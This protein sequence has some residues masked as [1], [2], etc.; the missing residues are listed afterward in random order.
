MSGPAVHNRL[1]NSLEVGGDM[2]HYC[3]LPVHS[4][5]HHVVCKDLTEV[6]NDRSSHL[7]DMPQP[8]CQVV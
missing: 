4:A 7:G 2:A 1:R 6:S 3:A 5:Y 8:W